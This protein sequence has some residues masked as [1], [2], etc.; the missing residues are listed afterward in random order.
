MDRQI[1]AN[2]PVAM[3]ERIP[4]SMSQPMP[5]PMWRKQSDRY[6]VVFE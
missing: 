2:L 3:P 1:K 4:E 6:A 5:K